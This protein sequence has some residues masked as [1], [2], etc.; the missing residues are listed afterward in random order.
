MR[1]PNAVNGGKAKD[2][3]Q[4]V[5]ILGSQS[6]Q[7]LVRCIRCC[8]IGA[9]IKVAAESEPTFTGFFFVNGIFYV[10][11][12][13]Q[14]DVS[15]VKEI[16]AWLNKIPSLNTASSTSESTVQQFFNS[17]AP[18]TLG[19]IKSMVET[20]CDSVDWKVGESFL[21]CHDGWCEHLLIVSDVRLTHRA[22]D[23]SSHNQLFPKSMFQVNLIS[24]EIRVVV[25]YSHTFLV[26]TVVLLGAINLNRPWA[27]IN[28]TCH[29]DE[30]T[31][32]NVPFVFLKQPIL[33]YLVTACR[34]QPHHF[35]AGK[36]FQV[37]NIVL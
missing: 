26:F 31:T 25:I 36:G 15:V 22:T 29:R 14:T 2:R 13:I 34:R 21:Y 37:G 35:F 6:L 11:S 32:E 8:S 10:D 23:S 30:R 33:S 9:S 1:P 16:A 24:M 12:D 4:D 17:T 3:Q 5:S 18:Y 28:V 19:Q 20:T 7:E 27:M